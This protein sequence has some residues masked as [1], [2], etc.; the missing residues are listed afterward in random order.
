MNKKKQQQPYTIKNIDNQYI[1]TDRIIKAEMRYLQ[2]KVV[3][4]CA[5]LRFVVYCSGGMCLLSECVMRTITQHCCRVHRC[6][7]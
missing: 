7:P 5:V 4:R 3:S 6:L 2:L 1:N